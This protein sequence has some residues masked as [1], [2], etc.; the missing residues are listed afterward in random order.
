MKSWGKR[1]IQ[2]AVLVWLGLMFGLVWGVADRSQ[3]AEKLISFP[4]FDIKTFTRTNSDLPE[5]VVLSLAVQ[6]GA[7][8][9]GTYGGGLARF[10]QGNWQV[11]QQEPGNRF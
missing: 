10:H 4:T 1:T 9:V 2:G 3:A 7:L 6:D 8:W 11:F 5:N